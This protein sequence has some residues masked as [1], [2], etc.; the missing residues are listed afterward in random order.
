MCG[1]VEEAISILLSRVAK[2]RVDCHPSLVAICY[3][4]SSGS[5]MACCDTAYFPALVDEYHKKTDPFDAY[6]L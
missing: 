6:F 4:S 1:G 5:L 2:G 3:C